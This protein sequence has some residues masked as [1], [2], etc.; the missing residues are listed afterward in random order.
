VIYTLFFLQG[1]DMHKKTKKA[2]K[3]SAKNDDPTITTYISLS[4]VQVGQ[5]QEEAPQ[6]PET[7]ELKKPSRWPKIEIPVFIIVLFWIAFLAVI[8]SIDMSYPLMTRFSSSS[9]KSTRNSNYYDMIFNSLAS[10]RRATPTFLQTTKEKLNTLFKPYSS[11]EVKIFTVAFQYE[12]IT[13]STF[14][15][16]DSHFRM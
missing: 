12:F 9:Q 1:S 5:L 10:M 8:I 3:K 11:K 16:M 6:L 2:K 15:N 7:P 4:E 14:K 13:V